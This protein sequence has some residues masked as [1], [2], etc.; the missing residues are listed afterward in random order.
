MSILIFTLIIIV[1]V[2]LMIWACNYL[3]LPEPLGGILRFMI[4][5]IA[6]VA[7]L[8]KAGIV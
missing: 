2:A 1:V 4:V 3:P 8:N 5:A 7:L 6:A